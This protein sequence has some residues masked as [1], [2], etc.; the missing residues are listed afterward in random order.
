M[1]REAIAL[2]AA[3]MVLPLEEVAGALASLADGAPGVGRS[4]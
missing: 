4:A 3:E 2:G 1:P